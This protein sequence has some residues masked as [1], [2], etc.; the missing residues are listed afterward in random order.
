MSATGGG[1]GGLGRRAMQLGEAE[2][3][4]LGATSMGR[5][6]FGYNVNARAPYESLGY[7]TTAVQMRKD[8]T[9]PFSG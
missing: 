1:T 2:A 7:E 5:N 4:R 9:T 8:L 6:V 3:R